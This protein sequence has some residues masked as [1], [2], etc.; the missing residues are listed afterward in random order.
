MLVEARSQLSP[1]W[2][3][4]D[5]VIVFGR[6]LGRE[7]DADLESFDV[8]SGVATPVPASQ[9]LWLPAWSSDGRYLAATTRDD[10][11]LMLFDFKASKWSPIPQAPAKGGLAAA[12]FSHDGKTLYFEDEKDLVLYRL[13]VPGG[14]PVPVVSRKDLRWPVLLYWGPWWGLAPDDSPLAMRD[15]GTWEIYAF[16]VLH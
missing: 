15:L 14:K 10:H 8:K 5:R 16:D 12:A 6:I 4:D 9:D 2:G 7:G 3:P 13:S 11:H 1:A